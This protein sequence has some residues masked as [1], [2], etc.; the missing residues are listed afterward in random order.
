MKLL[1]TRALSPA[2]ERRVA[3]E[4]DRVG[5]EVGAVPGILAD[6]KRVKAMLE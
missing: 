5:R 4:F 3:A 1:V 2:V 6:G